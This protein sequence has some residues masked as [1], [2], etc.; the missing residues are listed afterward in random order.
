[1]LFRSDLDERSSRV[2]D[3]LRAHGAGAGVRVGVFMERS[4]DML[5]GLLGVL[6]SG[7]AYVPL[8]PAFPDERL[9]YMIEDSEASLV[10][11]HTPMAD[12]VP[13]HALP[14]ILVDVHDD[15]PPARAGTPEVP[16]QPDDLAYVIYTSG[17]T[18]RPKGVAV[19]HRALVN[20]LESMARE[21]GFR[22]EDVL[23]SVTTLS[24]D[25]A[26]LELYLPLIQGGRVVLASRD[27]AS[28]PEQL[29][30]RLASSR[31]TVMQATPATWRMLVDSGWK[32]EANLRVLCGGEGLPRDLA[33]SLLA[34][35]GALWNMYGPTETTV[36]SATGRVTSGVG[37]VSIGRPIANTQFWVLDGKLQPM[38]VGVP[39]ELYI[40]GMG[41]ASG[42]WKRP[43]L[44]AERFVP[45]PFAGESGAR[46]YRT[47]DRGRWLPDG[48]LECLG[49]I[50]DQVKVR[51]FRIEPGEIEAVLREFD[52]VLGALV[53]AQDT[54]V[55]DRRLVAYVAHGTNPP[56][57]EGEL[58]AH[59]GR[60]LPSYMVP[61]AWVFL[62]AL[63][64]T[65]NGK[66]DRRAL[67]RLHMPEAV[68]QVEQAPPRTAT[69]KLLAAIW[70]EVLAVPS[71]GIDQNFF[72]LGGN[73]LSAVRVMARAR[74]KVG[75][76]A[77]LR[78]LFERPTIAGL[79]E[80]IDA[81]VLAQE[82]DAGVL[83]TAGRE[84]FEL[85]E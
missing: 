56:M 43:D 17:S 70:Q 69:E 84:E 82:P 25:I 44:V 60:R 58:R 12:A 81:L 34:R 57:D 28:D 64:L 54:S 46:M 2:A 30:E 77:G 5:V 55:S 18:G 19:S 26:A 6:K 79:A 31:A 53:L 13:S 23:L 3:R 4:L 7:A 10:L 51:G 72:K 15:A 21:P 75:V 29:M 83:A 76:N 22:E 47:G 80:A 42:Y 37:P 48:R 49:R 61:T 16:A 20:L 62:D 78:T 36:W 66:V 71:L 85:G 14:V 27:D 9:S 50:D 41:L 73:S 32:G 59:L 74:S 38:P 68:R 33:E 65:P 8:D 40:A 11:S 63:P 35:V 39:G 24:F 67:A 45:N 52:G 1:M